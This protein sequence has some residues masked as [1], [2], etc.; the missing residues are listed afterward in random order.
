V[1]LITPL[2][3]SSS[4]SLIHV[5]WWWYYCHGHWSTWVSNL[6]WLPSLIPP[7]LLKKILNDLTTLLWLYFISHWMVLVIWNLNCLA[8]QVPKFMRYPKI[9]K[10]SL[11][12]GL[13]GNHHPPSSIFHSKL[14]YQIWNVWFKMR[15]GVQKFKKWYH[16]IYDIMLSFD[17]NF[18]RNCFL[19]TKSCASGLIKWRVY[20]ESKEHF[21]DHFIQRLT[22]SCFSTYGHNQHRKWAI[23]FSRN[24][25]CAKTF[26]SLMAITESETG[27]A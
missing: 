19:C 21:N 6:K 18:C 12:H 16:M 7:K 20:D 27:I 14:G 10:V 1:T 8:S 2:L 3:S 17:V 4:Y 11:D 15:D 24:Q 25:N 9:W 22:G 26:C 5:Q 13:W 23:S